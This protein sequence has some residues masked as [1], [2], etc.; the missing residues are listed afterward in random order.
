MTRRRP[1]GTDPLAGVERVLVDGSNLAYALGRDS[2]DRPDGRD[3][4]DRRDGRPRPQAA[5]VASLRAAF[6]A[7]VRVEVV[8][9]GLGD[10]A[11][12]RRGTLA[13]AASNLFVEHA[14]RQSA[15]DAIDARVADQLAVDGPAGTWGIL[16]VTDDHELR[17]RV[18]Q[19]GARVAGT[20]WLA[21]RLARVGGGRPVDASGAGRAG[22][23]IGHRRP[24]RA[25][26]QPGSGR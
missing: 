24:P 16:V 25:Q 14:G 4:R 6:P 19:R 11:L 3:A 10:V 22:T 13:R 18:Q 7:A 26:R 9:D 23:S 2:R 8:F 12:G 17:G 20:A 1:T 5:I 21:G 15:D